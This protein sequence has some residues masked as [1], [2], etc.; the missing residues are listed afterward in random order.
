MNVEL[1]VLENPAKTRLF[2]AENASDPIALF[3][4]WFQEAAG[5]EP[6]DPEAVALAT[7][8]LEGRPSVRMVL[9]KGADERGFRF[10]TN[11]ESQKGGQLRENPRAAMCFHWKT[12]RRQVRLE[13]RVESLTAAEA[14]DY[15]HSRARR[16][17]ISAAV[18]QQSRPLA[19]R[20]Q[21][22]RAARDLESTCTA[23][24]PRPDYWRG[25]ILIPD[26][27]EF[28]QDGEFRLHDRMLFLRT[29]DSWSKVRLYP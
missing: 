3:K 27:I 21:L 1:S 9:M 4:E 14:D 2:D 20:E 24:V 26:H 22:E 18:S 11:A 15:F 28:W 10:Y 6:N 17:Q 12:Q 8:N 13:G 23:T 16:S 25:Y 5:T 7:S 29:A 19:S